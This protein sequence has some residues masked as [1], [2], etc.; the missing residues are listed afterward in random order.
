MTESK[1]Q[2]ARF[3]TVFAGGTLLSRILGLVRDVVLGALVPGASRDAFFFAFMFPN[4]LRDMLGEGASN[5]AFVPVFS[6]S[7]EKDS[8][9]H[10]RG[11]VASAMGAMIIVFGVLTVLGICLVPVIPWLL[12]LIRPVLGTGA[13]SA[14]ELAEQL[15]LTLP[16]VRWLFPYLFLIGMAVFA[17]A[18]LFVARHYS[19]PSWSPALLNI[20]LI[21]CCLALHPYFP[22][23]AWALVAGV[24]IGGLAQLAVM[25]WAM[26]KHTGILRP[27][28]P[29]KHPGVAKIFL[30]LGP[31]IVG[32]ATGEVNKVVDKL[33]ALS[34]E[35]D[36]VSALFYANRLVQLPLSVFG[37]AVAAV[38]LP[39]MSSASARGEEDTLRAT[40]MHGLRQSFFLMAPAVA[41]LLVLSHP[42][43]RLLFERGQF[44]P[45]TTEKTATALFY[46]SL[47]LLSYSWI[48]VSVQG[49]YAVKNTKTPVIVASACMLLNI[50]LNFVLVGP[51]GYRGLALAT[52]LSFTVNFALLYV[53]LSVRFGRL[54]DGPM[55]VA[56]GKIT[57]AAILMAAVAYGAHHRVAWALGTETFLARVAAVGSAVALA[58]A[59][60]AVVCRTLGVQEAHDFTKALQRRRN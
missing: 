20:A 46:Y 5:A 14:G 4:M 48:K 3:A 58:A 35:Q 38:L 23:P 52:A 30:L 6:E 50:L 36:T 24:W 1:S 40:L 19:T 59:V 32:Q 56:L 47:G 15:R 57:G 55:A 29:W 22:D 9:A 44:G 21:V 16:L 7:K 26:K 11:L 41:G 54:W 37:L 25:L 8:E 51:M 39:A 45:D 2:L 27:A 34:L 10:Y 31:V 18:P 28:L 43:V 49:F 42:I 17:M 53:L 60:Y 33:F 13:K 12:D